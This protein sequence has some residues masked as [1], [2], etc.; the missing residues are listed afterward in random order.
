MFLHTATDETLTLDGEPLPYTVY[1]ADSVPAQAVGVMGRRGVP[2]GVALVFSFARV[3]PRLIHMFGVRDPIT[4]WW[5]AEGQ[6]RR[7][8]RLGAWC[9]VGRAEAD[10]VVE[11]PADASR[12]SVGQCVALLE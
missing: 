8:E 2:D 12:P 1:R 3:R 10:L 6:V 9:G 4:T 5:V 7:S 11:L